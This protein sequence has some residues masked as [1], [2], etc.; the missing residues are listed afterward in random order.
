[1]EVLQTG[2]RLNSW[3]HCTGLATVEKESGRNTS[4]PWPIYIILCNSPEE[5][6]SQRT[7]QQ[8]GSPVTS[9]ESDRWQRSWRLLVASASSYSRKTRQRLLCHFRKN[10]GSG[11]AARGAGEVV[12]RRSDA[13]DVRKQQNNYR[14]RCTLKSTTWKM[15]SPNR[16][17]GSLYMTRN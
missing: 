10:P 3:N 13:E 8:D 12:G 5:L 7:R 16:A 2:Y 17:K 9:F 1:V 11:T 6:L 15:V 4:E 14:S